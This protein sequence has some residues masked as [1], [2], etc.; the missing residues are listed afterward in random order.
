VR[1]DLTLNFGLRYDLQFLPDPIET[2]TDNVAP[3][4]GFAYS[5]NAK[6]VMRGSFG[7]YYDRIPTRATSNALQRDGSKYVVAILSRTSPGAPVFP[8][9][10]AARPSVL[11][12]KPS[13][14]RIDPEIEN[15]SSQQANLQIERELPW[16]SSVSIGY[17]HLRGTHIILSRNVNVPRC[18]A[19]ADSNLCRP[20]P[21]FGNVSRYEGSGDS[22]Y[23][24]MFVSF[25]KRQGRWATARVSY[26]LSKA[27]DDSGN[28]F[29][30]TPQDNFNLRGEQG[31]SDNNQRHRLTVSG[32]FNAPA[33]FENGFAR[34]ALGGF[35][36]GYIFTYAS[37]LPFNVLAGSDLN[38]DSTNNDRPSGLA[39]NTGRGFDFASFDLSLSRRFRVTEKLNLE[40]IAEGFNLFNRA[41][42]SVPNN[43]FGTGAQPPATFGQPT[44]AFDPRQMQ[45]GLRLAF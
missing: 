20:D 14:T 33:A 10:L 23:N 15:S 27:I 36:V 43:N 11:T 45:V 37:R 25:N 44:A 34:E 24:G 28:F 42:F 38:G 2:D 30:S 40:L 31:L 22:Y 9:V 4:F 29:F 3:R 26:T 32:T 16:D 35:E 17:V 39:R 6:T 18:P 5:P 8:D 1:R 7:L 19:A 13:V 12:T 41:N 21:N